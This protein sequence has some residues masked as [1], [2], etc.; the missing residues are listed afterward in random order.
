[1]NAEKERLGEYQFKLKSKPKRVVEEKELKMLDENEVKEQILR[2]HYQRMCQYYNKL[3]LIVRS[4]LGHLD[5][6]K[7]ICGHYKKLL[8]CQPFPELR[9]QFYLFNRNLFD[10]E[11]QY[12]RHSEFLSELYINVGMNVI[13]SPAALDKLNVFMSALMNK[14]F[15]SIP[16]HLVEILEYLTQFILG[17][18]FDI[19]LKLFSVKFYLQLAKEERFHQALQNIYPLLI[20]NINL[21][22]QFPE[23]QSLL[24]EVLKVIPE[25]RFEELLE[26][27]LNY[28]NN[29]KRI[30]LQSILLSGRNFT[31]SF[32]DYVKLRILAAEDAEIAEL[33]T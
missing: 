2:E 6:Q 13:P 22:S 8:E 7:Y 4:P 31:L 25:E 29:S 9:F 15:K 23:T 3:V 5:F 10:A 21:L 26:D 28:L 17:L 24:V 18:G 20:E 27:V 12:R 33:A 19:S 11:P 16:S 1:M 30:S 32:E 14:E